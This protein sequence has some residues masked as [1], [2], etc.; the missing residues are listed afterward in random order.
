M[1][2]AIMR[3]EKPTVN[4]TKTYNNGAKILSS[5]LLPMTAVDKSNYKKLLIDSGYIKE[6]QLK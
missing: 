6:E 2:D 4:D 5:S 3:G 1:A